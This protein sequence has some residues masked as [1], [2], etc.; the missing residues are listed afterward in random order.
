MRPVDAA[1]WM[2]GSRPAAVL[3]QSQNAL[4]KRIMR[5]WWF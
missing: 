2:P 5:A 1:S 4:S 3:P